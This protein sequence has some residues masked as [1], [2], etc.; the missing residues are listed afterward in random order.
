MSFIALMRT[1]RV[2]GWNVSTTMYEH[3]LNIMSWYPTAITL[4]KWF[5]SFLSPTLVLNREVAELYVDSE[6]TLGQMLNVPPHCPSTR[7]LCVWDCVWFDVINN[8]IDSFKLC[9]SNGQPTYNGPPFYFQHWWHDDSPKGN[10]EWK[11]MCLFSCCS[12]PQ[13]E[14]LPIG[15]KSECMVAPDAML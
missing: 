11:I 10:C 2:K 7:F 13:L 3:P 12:R 8:D 6:V 1:S 14:G 9:A 4:D 15:D 5:V